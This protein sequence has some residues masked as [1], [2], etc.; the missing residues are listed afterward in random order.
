MTRLPRDRAASANIHRDGRRLVASLTT[1]PSRVHLL[2]QSIDSLWTQRRRPDKLQI[3]VPRYSRRERAA[4]PD[5]ASLRTL[6][7]YPESWLVIRTGV[8][9][10]GPITKLLS[11]LEDERDSS[12]IILLV[13]DDT[14]YRP[15]MIR[16]MLEHRA[17]HPARKAT[18]FSGRLAVT[19]MKR[20][21]P[22]VT[23]K[24]CSNT[25]IDTSVTFLENFSGGFFDRDCFPQQVEPIRAQLASLPPEC[26]Y[27]DDIVIGALLARANIERTVVSTGGVS[28]WGHDNHAPNALRADGNLEWRNLFNYRQLVALGFFPEPVVPWPHN[29]PFTCRRWLAR[30]AAWCQAMSRPH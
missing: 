6:L 10:E 18:G 5:E 12:T 20:F 11:T 1:I 8:A 26:F 25:T 21:A 29:V 13:D 15:D 19:L 2:P 14:V 4:Y 9:D 17:E 7:P 3:N 30:A 22:T 24:F 23:L 16:I 28:Q 27:T